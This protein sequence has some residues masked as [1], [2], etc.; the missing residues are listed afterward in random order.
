MAAPTGFVPKQD[1]ERHKA[2]ILELYC[3][4]GLPL[5]RKAGPKEKEPCVDSIMRDEHNFVAR[6]GIHSV[7]V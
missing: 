5:T 7:F 6:S 1:W 4:R 3:E 2:T